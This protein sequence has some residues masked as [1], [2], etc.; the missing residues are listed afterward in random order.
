MVSFTLR[1]I[2]AGGAFTH[3]S[4]ISDLTVGVVQ[5]KPYLY[6]ASRVDGGLAALSLAAGQAASFISQVDA[7]AASGTY[8]V[9]D[10]EIT[11]LGGATVLASAGRYDNEFAYRQIN[12]RGDFGSVATIPSISTSTAALTDIEI[13]KF[14]SS[15]FMIAGRDNA[16]GLSVFSMSSGLGLSYVGG[17]SDD[18]AVTL[19][20]VSDLITY[21]TGTANLIFASS[22]VEH[23]VT[24]MSIDASGS[25]SVVDSVHG[26]QGYGI[27]QATELSTAETG[28][29]D[30]LLVGAAGSGNITVFEIG[31][32]GRLSLRDMV[33]DSLETR[34]RKVTALETF[35]YNDRA[36]V[37]AGGNDGGMTLFELG[38]NGKLY[39]VTNVLDT[40]AT[41]L[42]SVSAI[43]VAIIGGDVQVFVSSSTEAGITQFSLNLGAIGNMVAPSGNSTGALGSPSDDFLV[44][45]DDRNT[46]W[47]M[48]GNDRIVDGGSIDELYGGL[49]ADTF[50]FVRDGMDDRVMD[51]QSGIDRIDLSDFD[52]I[53]SVAALE[54]H[55]TGNGARIEVS[56]EA[57]VLVSLDGQPLTAADFDASD[58]IF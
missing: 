22:S 48:N 40:H 51:Y 57:I 19:A 37:L 49:G 38:P 15:T 10:V 53:Y 2:H 36:F 56:S 3:S 28:G 24:S 16:A 11:D 27:Y 50:V 42:D 34:F 9:E 26:L 5:G 20:N 7:S 47:G 21:S 35:D 29:K 58:F 41:T 54:I 14:G 13:M 17:V 43:E 46:L 32:T 4:G 55:T 52:R 6:A 25:I 18:L 12:A 1:A 31:Q 44:G 8:G 30:F 23:G 33:W 39:F 45:T